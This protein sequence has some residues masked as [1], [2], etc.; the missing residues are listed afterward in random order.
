VFASNQDAVPASSRFTREL[1]DLRWFFTESDGDTGLR[2]N[3]PAVVMQ[4]ALGPGAPS[5]PMT[6]PDPF[7]LIAAER[8]RHVRRRLESLDDVT[9]S[10]L[11]VCSVESPPSG[12]ASF[13][14]GAALAPQTQAAVKAWQVS[15]TSRSVVDWLSR[16]PRRLDEPGIPKLVSAIQAEADSLLAKALSAYRDAGRKGVAHAR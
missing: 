1:E 7:G 9:V 2:S 10:Q 15:G 6:E 3:F 8:S 12:L 11:Y 4:I 16:L 13:G 5:L 14:L